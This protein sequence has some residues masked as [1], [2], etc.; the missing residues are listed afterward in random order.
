MPAL[1]AAHS[2]YRDSACPPK[3]Q[4][5]PHL[6]TPVEHRWPLPRGGPSWS[7]PPNLA[8]PPYSLKPAKFGKVRGRGIDRQH[9]IEAGGVGDQ[10]QIS[11]SSSS[12]RRCNLYR[13]CEATVRLTTWFKISIGV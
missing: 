3:P 2:R 4:A 12:D 10:R 7:M 8:A 13:S 1:S 6:F 5:H 9:A 11:S